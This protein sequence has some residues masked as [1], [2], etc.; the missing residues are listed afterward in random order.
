[1]L[2]RDFQVGVLIA[3]SATGAGLCG[4]NH[5]S[6]LLKTHGCDI[7][8][9]ILGLVTDVDVVIRAAVITSD[10]K[11]RQITFH[12]QS[13]I[14]GDALSAMLLPHNLTM[15]IHIG[16]IGQNRN[17]IGSLKFFSNFIIN[18]INAH[19]LNSSAF[20]PASIK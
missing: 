20:I 4:E 17:I 10:G 19:S 8:T 13:G 16:R 15:V 6:A 7:L 5:S 18:I 2:R 14:I 1:M 9:Q 11:P 12:R 3:G